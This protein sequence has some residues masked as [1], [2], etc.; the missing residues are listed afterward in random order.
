MNSP[1]DATNPEDDFFGAPPRPNFLTTEENA[2][3]SFDLDDPPVEVLTEEQDVELRDTWANKFRPE[4]DLEALEDLQL[5][6]VGV[7]ETAEDQT[8][9]REGVESP[10]PAEIDDLL[11]IVPAERLLVSSSCGCGRVPHDQAIR[12]MRGLVKAAASVG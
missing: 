1:F 12:L 2:M 8:W 5:P 9:A 7:P 6:D 11:D 3:Y 10:G 4:G